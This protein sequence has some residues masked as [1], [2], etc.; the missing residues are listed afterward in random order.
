MTMVK[1]SV[2][3]D[4]QEGTYLENETRVFRYVPVLPRRQSL[5]MRPLENR[6]DCLEA[7]KSSFKVGGLSVY[8]MMDCSESSDRES[9]PQ[10]Y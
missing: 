6:V 1:D 9:R 7:F 5:G 8:P 3:T 10:A 4:V 2:S